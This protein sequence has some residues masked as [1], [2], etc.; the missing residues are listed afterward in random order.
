MVAPTD[1]ELASYAAPVWGSD[2][3]GRC[4]RCSEPCKRYG[5]GANP[6]CRD[7]FSVVAAAWG[8]GGQA[9]GLQRVE[10]QAG[11]WAGGP[12]QAARRHRSAAWLIRS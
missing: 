8:P 3:A 5:T 9:E 1:T 12:R 10:P 7:C 6:L 4:T 11:R 2:V